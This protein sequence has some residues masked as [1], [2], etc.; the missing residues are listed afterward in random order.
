MKH[1]TTSSSSTTKKKSSSIMPKPTSTNATS[2]KSSTVTLKP[3]NSSQCKKVG[4]KWCSHQKKCMHEKD[5]ENIK[6]R[7]MR[8]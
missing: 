5:K 2:T 1:S 7:W 6:F 4:M 8:D 3:T